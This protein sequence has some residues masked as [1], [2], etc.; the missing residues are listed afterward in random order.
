[1]KKHRSDRRKLRLQ[2]TTIR[3]LSSLGLAR[4]RGGTEGIIAGELGGAQGAQGGTDTVS[5]NSNDN[6]LPSVVVC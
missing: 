1:M 6:C 5:S 3:Q 2:R 4:V